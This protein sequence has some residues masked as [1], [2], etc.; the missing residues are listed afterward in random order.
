MIAIPLPLKAQFEKSLRNKLVP[1]RLHGFY[2]KWLRYYLDFCAKYRFSPRQKESLPRFIGKLREK[3]QTK[4]QQE[5]AVKSITLYYEIVSQE[6]KNELTGKSPNYRIGTALD[7]PK[8]YAIREGSE[9]PV[10][11]GKVVPAPRHDFA[12]ASH[13]R[14][15]SRGFRSE[16]RTDTK[17]ERGASWKAQ[18]SSLEDEIRKGGTFVQKLHN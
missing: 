14:S 16:G 17:R 12:M 8:I 4:T 9:T 11:D 7:N 13:G 2:K 1:D 10:Q 18:F 5:Q 6:A 15:P 3:Q